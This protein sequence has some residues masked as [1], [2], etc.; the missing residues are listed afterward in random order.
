MYIY[1]SGNSGDLSSSYTGGDLYMSEEEKKRRL[2]EQGG[3]SPYATTTSTTASTST[4][5]TSTTSTP[6]TSTTTTQP[7]PTSSVTS[8]TSTPTKTFSQMQAEGQARP[9][10]PTADQYN[11]TISQTNVG[12]APEPTPTPSEPIPQPTPTTSPTYWYENPQNFTPLQWEQMQWMK[13]NNV[14]SMPFGYEYTPGGG[15]QR[16]SFQDVVAQGYKP[17]NYFN[18]TNWA[19]P[20][21]QKQYDQ[22]QWYWNLV[23]DQYA[24]VPDRVM[25]E[26]GMTGSAPTDTAVPADAVLSIGGWPTGTQQP[27]LAPSAPTFD[28]AQYLT[29]MMT[30]TGAPAPGTPPTAAVPGV[31]PGGVDPIA[32]IGGNT[33][34]TG[35][36]NA[37]ASLLR[38]PSAFDNEAVMQLYSR[39]GGQIDD[40]FAQRQTGLREEM[41]GR[42]LSDSSIMGGRLADLNVARRSA[43]TELAD[44]LATQRAQDYASALQN[45]IGLGQ[46]QRQMQF[47]EEQGRGTLDLSRQ[48]LGLDQTQ[49]QYL[50]QMGLLDRYMNFGQQA[51]DN[52]LRTAEFNRLMQNDQDMLLYKLLG[53]GG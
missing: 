8:T 50:Q 46:T 31:T 17:N 36:D 43:Q 28:V 32:A 52:D 13:A 9:N 25:P 45:A 53:L 7:Q 1:D 41:A 10:P 23:K 35:L 33:G 30:R 24:G 47:N 51:F 44:R 38:N 42:G 15:I 16:M 39:L 48:R 6:T 5:P 4:Q 2:A 11:Q 3:T 40:E 12:V 49:Q 21:Y 19:D 18:E 34:V 26:V 14:S 37:I 27:A 29:Q 20:S 22:N